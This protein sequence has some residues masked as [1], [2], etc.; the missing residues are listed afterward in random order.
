MDLSLRDRLIARK[1]R[2]RLSKSVYPALTRDRRKAVK[3]LYNLTPDVHDALLQSQGGKCAIGS[4]TSRVD[5]NSP[6]DH[7]HACCSGK[8]SCGKCVRGILCSRHNTGLGAFQDNP[9]ELRD[10]ALYVERP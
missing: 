6:I 2:V 5:L 10:A 7:D 8:R 1:P 3:H 4:C 9:N